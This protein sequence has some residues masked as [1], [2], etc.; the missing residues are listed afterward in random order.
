MSSLESEELQALWTE[1]VLSDVLQ[2]GSGDGIDALQQD[3]YVAQLTAVEVMACKVE[4]KLLTVVAGDG[5]LTFQLSLGG[6]QL[7]VGEGVLHDAVQLAM[8]KAKAV[9]YVVMVTAEVD[10]PAAGVAVGDRG[11]LD[12]IDE[13]MTFA[14]AKVKAG[15]HA[16]T[17]KDIVK[18][19]EGHAMFVVPGIGL[20]TEHDM[21]LMVGVLSF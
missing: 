12:G 14:K 9:V 19:I 1:D 2:L 7:T 5:Q 17:T 3:V 15:V 20:T 11:T 8:D 21:S 6:S 13:A 4:G 18:Q 16:W 10:A